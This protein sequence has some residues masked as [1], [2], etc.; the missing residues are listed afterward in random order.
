MKSE[1]V[2]IRT[3]TVEDLDIVLATEKRVYL[4]PWSRRNYEFEVKQNRFAIP[5]VMEYQ[6]EIIGHCVAW[7]LFETYHIATIVI[8]PEHQGQGLGKYLLDYMLSKS[9]MADHALLEVRESNIRARTLYQ[10]YGF[11][12]IGMRK[13][14][15]KD[16]EN[17][18]VMRKELE[19]TNS[20]E[21]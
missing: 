15:Y 12:D 19:L 17:A 9:K 1:D 16:G 8:M 14:Y 5:V 20:D 2:L 3:M 11:R 7:D 13:R 4:T 18:I 6:G 10:Q 21:K